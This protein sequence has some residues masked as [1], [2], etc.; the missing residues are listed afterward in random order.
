MEFNYSDFG[1]SDYDNAQRL[2]D[3]IQNI[4]YLSTSLNEFF[5]K[6]DS[7][8]SGLEEIRNNTISPGVQF[9]LMYFLGMLEKPFKNKTVDA[10]I[11]KA[12]LNN[13]N[14]EDF[15]K[16]LTN[17]ES[18]IKII[19]GLD[20]NQSTEYIGDQPFTFKNLNKVCEI[21]EQHGLEK[22]FIQPFYLRDKIESYKK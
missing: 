6:V 13:G 10:K 14:N 1:D 15:R 12:L 8:K 19:S 17:C 9:L 22:E 3:A 18:Q 16:W 7:F 5:A 21:L 4:S 2:E 11:L 20:S